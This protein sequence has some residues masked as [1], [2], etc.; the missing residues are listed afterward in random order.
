MCHN[1]S[2]IAAKHRCT[3]STQA[4]IVGGLATRDEEFVEL[5]FISQSAGDLL[6]FHIP[7]SMQE[8][9]CHYQGNERIMNREKTRA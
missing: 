9:D 8:D 2:V 3:N 4:L 1:N 7:Q 5:D 6:H